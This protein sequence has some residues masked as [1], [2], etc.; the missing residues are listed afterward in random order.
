[1]AG[2]GDS[3]AG[4]KLEEPTTMIQEPAV[5]L[6][7]GR[8]HRTPTADKVPLEQ[9]LSLLSPAGLASILIPCCGQLEYTKLLVPSLLRHTRQPFELIFL[10]IGSLDGT[11]EYLVGLAAGAQVRVEVVRT[12]TDLGIPQVIEDGLKQ[13]RGEFLVLLNN[14]TIV[15][16]N[17]LNQLIGLAQLSPA[18]GL[19]GP[20]TNHAAAPQLVET[21]PYRIGPTKSAS[22]KGP[23][24]WLLNVDAMDAFARKWRDEHRGKWGEVE[25]LGGFC[26]LVKREVLSRIGHLKDNWDLGLFDS[27]QLS[28]KARVAGFSLACCRDLYVHHFGS[29]VFAHGAP[30]AE[31][32]RAGV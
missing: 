18:I 1:M 10:D 24:D 4:G 6:Q 13:A 32:E 11:A 30:K 2:F 27:D 17:W 15:T 8:N 20:M 14:D 23:G 25:R 21:V 31:A 28:I 9:P 29:R 22:K 16:D 12:Y 26:L 19:V 3:F 5:P 7:P